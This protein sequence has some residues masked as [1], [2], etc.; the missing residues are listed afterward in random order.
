MIM[1][2]LRF[3]SQLGLL[4]AM[5]LSFSSQA[6]IPGMVKIPAGRYLMGASDDLGRRDEYPQ[7][8]VE[9]KGFWMDATEVSNA[10]FADFINA[11]GYVTTAERSVDWEEIKKQLPAGT[12]KPADSLLR[13][14]SMVF[15]A[16]KEA[17]DLRDFG[18][19]WELKPGANWR[20]PEGPGSTWKG[21]ENHPVVHV[22]WED[23]QAYAAWAGKRLPTEAEWEWAARGGLKQALYP[24]GNEEIDQGKPK[25][26][27]WQ[28]V[29]PRQDL[30]KDGFAMK[31]API[32]SFLPNG[33]GLYDMAGNVWEWCADWYHA[34]YYQEAAKKTKSLQPKG[35]KE[36]YDPED[37][38]MP[39]RVLRGGSF[40]CNASYCASYRVSARMKS[41]PDT[42][43]NHTGFRCVKDL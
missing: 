1:N 33:Y 29:F 36:S 2:T 7:H 17:V 35:P 26:N 10:Q 40:L 25:A 18:T 37:P 16:P 8:W 34:D 6:Q 41:S 3:L 15:T 9:L 42:G 5:E 13:P 39:K 12:P 20:Q 14:C 23:A 43:L 38:G 28:G 24:W 19:W 11:T 22:S 30:G 27:T 21:R 4:L 32:K 31:T